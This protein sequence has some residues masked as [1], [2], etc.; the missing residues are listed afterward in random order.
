M[1]AADQEMH[2]LQVLSA[3]EEN[4]DR[5]QRAI[6]E[7][8]GLSLAKVNYCLKRLVEKGHI[9]LRNVARN[10]N[11]LGYLYLLTPGGIR[12]KSRLTYHFMR[13]AATQYGEVHGRVRSRLE[14]IASSGVNAVVF[15]GAGEIA[16]VCY[17]ALVDHG[18][19]QLAAV[20]D[21]ERK[22]SEFHGMT[23]RAEEWLRE[24]GDGVPVLV[25]EPEL[26]ARARKLV[27]AKR[28]HVLG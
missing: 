13:R 26:L 14:H 1:P 20:V 4:S 22:N 12:E 2:L 15:Y 23:V 11:K 19:M 24:S 10:P 25:C 3:L 6:A 28:L 5:P 18:R 21:D 9:K 7:A 27:G 16:E 17:H 8:T